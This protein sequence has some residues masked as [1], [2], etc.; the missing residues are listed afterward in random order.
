MEWDEYF[1]NLAEQV[2]LKSKDRSR[3]VGAVIVDKHHVIRSTGYNGFP[4]GIND[5]IE[6]RHE[7]P[8]KYFWVSHAE[9][10]SIVTSARHGTSLENCTMYVTAMPC[11]NCARLIVQAGIRE[12]V[13]KPFEINPNNKVRNWEEDL[14]RTVMLFREAR[15][16]LRVI[17]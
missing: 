16:E 12:V 6:E 5:N 11:M 1:L 15:V 17:K 14:K 4:M 10:N 13:C 7:K 9:E 2:S 8:E 3:K